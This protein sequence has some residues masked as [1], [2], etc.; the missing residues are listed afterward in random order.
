MAQIGTIVVSD[1]I[2]TNAWIEK[3][4]AENPKYGVGNV[5]TSGKGVKYIPINNDKNG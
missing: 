5:E 4:K 1:T 2:N 3:I